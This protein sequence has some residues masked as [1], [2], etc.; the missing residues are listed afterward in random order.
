MDFNELKHFIAIVEHGS[1]TNAA[2]NIYVSQPTLSKSIDKLEKKLQL[3]LLERSTRK[4]TVT[5]AGKL[6]YTQAQ[7]ILGSTQELHLLL[8]DLKNIPTGEINIGVPPLIGTLFFSKIAQYF[9]KSNPG[10]KL[11][12][13]EWGAKRVETLVEEGKVDIGLVVLP[14]NEEKFNILP[15]LED[16]F[17]LFTHKDHPLAKKESV[18]MEELKE[19]D[20]ILFTEEFSLHGLVIHQC[21]KAGFHPKIAY[22]SSQWDLM[23]ELIIAELGIT[24][25]PKSAYEKIDESKVSAIPIQTP[26]TWKLGVITKKESYQSFALRSLLEFFA[27]DFKNR[28]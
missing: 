14:V 24:L 11:H 7:K 20:F 19:E 27:D 12:L 9:G 6:V 15:F 2:K 28:L 18:Q 10:I 16:E 23:I 5:D 4:I 17:M 25:F 21:E 3:K 13:V 26:P 8:D 1:F 22:K